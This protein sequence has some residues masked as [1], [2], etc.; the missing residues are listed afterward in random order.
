MGIYCQIESQD[1]DTNTQFIASAADLASSFLN[2]VG[3]EIHSDN[4]YNNPEG[5]QKKKGLYSILY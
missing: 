5:K 3:H 2:Q 4:P 1:T